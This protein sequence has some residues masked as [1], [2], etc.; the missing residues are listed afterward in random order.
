MPSGLR[1]TDLVCWMYCPC[2][3]GPQVL[4]GSLKPVSCG[5]PNILVKQV[6]D[7]LD[8][9]RTPSLRMKKYNLRAV[10]PPG[11][12]TLVRLGTSQPEIERGPLGQTAL[13]SQ[14]SLVSL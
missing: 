9:P 13:H 6:E 3:A 8:R 2:A 14:D 12:L 1:L 4:P 11:P 10:L 7:S 5:M